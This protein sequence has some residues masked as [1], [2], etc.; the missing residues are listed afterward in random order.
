MIRRLP[1]VSDHPGKLGEKPVPVPAHRK[2][3]S[4]K[5]DSG[6]FPIV[7]IGA[8]AGG[9]EAIELFLKNVPADSGMAFVIIQH[10][11]PTHKEILTE[12]LQ[13]ITTMTTIQARDRMTVKPDCVY[14]IPSNRDMSILHGVLHL[15]TPS[16]PRGLRL[17]IDFFFRSLAL[18]LQERGI[19]VVLSGM[20]TDGTQGA[21][22]IKEKGGIV[23]VQEPS[24]AK[25]DGMPRSVIDSKMV[26]CIAPPGELPAKILGLHRLP[27][28]PVRVP[29]VQKQ[30]DNA[31]EKAVI[32]LRVTT[33]HDFSQYKKT[34][35]Y[36]RIERRMGVHQIDKI[37]TYVRFLQQ[38][39]PEI[40]FLFRELLIGVTNFFRDPAEWSAIKTRVLPGLIEQYPAGRQLRAWVAGCSTGE[41]AY[42]LAMIF[43]EVL[44]EVK[45]KGRF[46]LQ[47]F[48]TDLDK[49]A[50]DKARQGFYQSI[51][52]GDVSPGRRTRFF[53]RE[54]ENYRICK[55]IR[56]MVIFAPQ[57]LVQDPPF[58]RI[59]IL[60]CRN[61]LIYL[62]HEMQ[63]KLLPLFHY[64]LNPG[65]TLFLGSAESID[66]FT[67]LFTQIEINS[68]LFVRNDV[69]PGKEPIRFSSTFAPVYQGSSVQPD[70]IPACEKSLQIMADRFFLQ[71]F[72]PAAVLVNKTGDI[73]YSTGQT[74]P[75]LQLSAGKANL[76][77]FSMASEEIRYELTTAFQKACRRKEP[78]CARNLSV[79]VGRT[80][81]TFDLAVQTVQELGIL[82][83]M[84]AIV[85]SDA[86]VPPGKTGGAVPAG[87]ARVRSSRLVE[88]EKELSRIQDEL[89]ISRDE[90]HSSQEELRAANEELQ[91]T[92]EELQSTNEELTTSKEEMQSLNEELQT[93]NNELQVKVDEL[94][95][96]NN[97]MKN[98]LDST[99][100][101][102][103]FLTN[104][105][106]V[107]RFTIHASRL[108]NLIATDVGRPI[109]D[110]SSVFL[111]PDLVEDAGEVLRTLVFREKQ[112]ATRDRRRFAVRIM[113]YRTLDN[114]IDGVV[115]TFTDIGKYSLPRSKT[116]KNVSDNPE[117]IKP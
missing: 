14:V 82:Q 35:L 112:I 96:M 44:D 106:K 113:P 18:D 45:P 83:N 105:F 4:I 72:S 86:A 104:E 97:D 115:I 6:I 24:T 40:E 21:R 57:N 75:F 51:I 34:T 78:V 66:G 61:L 2:K 1:N 41:E 19:A 65:G 39:P 16:A 7:G 17:P 56:Q 47:V 46:T 8:S 74:A 43:R 73:I 13:R 54:E 12:L 23:L 10:L 55:E 108:I 116:K 11:D 26:D 48:A 49:N 36:R 85:F 101:A 90:M 102:T 63:K 88:L 89:R 109:M 92:N 31:L 70:E 71:R 87:S 27:R 91:S 68:K 95:G 50:I 117:K 33:G 30:G 32:L 15:F 79:T 84:V 94:S 60:S 59:D 107:R 64:S 114:V 58:T 3:N 111:Y 20:G 37:N 29:L 22:S 80:P 98:L 99:D 69:P 25:F 110:L 100:I 103:V 93:V 77:I 28:P 38:N 5:N 76:N 67:D 62:T 42:S 9:L 53:V 81:R 52:T